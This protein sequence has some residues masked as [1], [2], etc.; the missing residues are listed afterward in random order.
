MEAP[1]DPVSGEEIDPETAAYTSAYHGR[2]FAFASFEHKQR[3]DGTPEAYVG[4]RLDRPA[5]FPSPY[6]GFAQEHATPPPL[7]AREV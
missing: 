4:R 6:E 7:M 1:S 5:R 2:T 3:F